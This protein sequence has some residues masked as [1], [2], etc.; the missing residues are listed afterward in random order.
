VAWTLEIEFQFYLLAP[1]VMRAYFRR[2]VHVRQP[3][4]GIFSGLFL[5]LE[6]YY[7]DVLAAYH[8]DMTLLTKAHFFLVGV[9]ICDYHLRNERFLKSKSIW[10]DLLFG[11]ALFLLPALELS[12]YWSQH[13]LDRF[14]FTASIGVL[15]CGVHKGVFANRLL[16][17]PYFYLAGGMCYS[18]YMLHYPFFVLLGGHVDFI[19]ST[20][21]FGVDLAVNALWVL[22]VLAVPVLSF[23]LLIERPC[24]DPRWPE[25]LRA[26]ALQLTRRT[27]SRSG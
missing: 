27:D 8:L 24:M 18:L 14:L 17:R 4:L 3:L 19:D 16:T 5:G 1:F 26:R 25:R 11:V 20:G 15:F 10:W 7:E 23:Y 13:L 6:V 9:A 12:S 22:P 2:P 21:F